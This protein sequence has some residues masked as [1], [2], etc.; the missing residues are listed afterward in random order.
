MF[1]THLSLHV[2]NLT[3]EKELSHFKLIPYL[4]MPFQCSFFI[5][6]LFAIFHPIME[7]KTVFPKLMIW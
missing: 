4:I 5:N 2:L 1:A 6:K 7:E 3:D